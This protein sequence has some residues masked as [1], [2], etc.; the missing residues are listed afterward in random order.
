VHLVQDA[1]SLIGLVAVALVVA[2]GLRPGRTGDAAMPR[3]LQRRERS[4]WIAAYGLAAAGL[5][6]IFFSLARRPSLGGN[7]LLAVPL[8]AAAIASLRGMGAALVLVSIALAMRL[9]RLGPLPDS[10]RQSAT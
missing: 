8:S 9:R 6:G 5:S 2:Y 3:R 7:P 1:N 4:G 10:A